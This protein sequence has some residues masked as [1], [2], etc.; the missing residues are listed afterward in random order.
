MEVHTA[1]RKDHRCNECGRRIPI[2]AKYF[3]END[4]EIREHTN[5]LLF[6]NEPLLPAGYNQNRKVNK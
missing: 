2:G 5:C 3:V 4:G 1:T 6:E